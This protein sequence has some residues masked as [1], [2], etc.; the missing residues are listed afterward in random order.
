MLDVF[1]D[2]LIGNLSLDKIKRECTHP[3]ALPEIRT[4]GLSYFCTDK[5]RHAVLPQVEDIQADSIRVEGIIITPKVIPLVSR[6][7]KRKSGKHTRSISQW[8]KFHNQPT[9]IS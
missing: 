9:N 5:F 6:L 7:R 4:D 8:L 3:F 1:P 2:A